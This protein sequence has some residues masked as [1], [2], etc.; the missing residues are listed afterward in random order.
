MLLPFYLASSS[1]KN[2]AVCESYRSL[3][4]IGRQSGIDHDRYENYACWFLLFW[5]IWRNFRS[6]RYQKDI[7]FSRRTGQHSVI[8]QFSKCKCCA[9]WSSIRVKHQSSWTISGMIC[10]LKGLDDQI[11]IGFGWYIP[12]DN[13]SGKKIHNDTKVIP[14]TSGFEICKVT[15]PDQVGS[16]LMKVLMQVI[17]ITA[18][19]LFW[20]RNGFWFY[21]GHRWKLP[22]AHQA[23]H[24]TDTDVNAIVTT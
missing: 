19:W 1:L 22:G 8:K 15:C 4:Y 6:R 3:R 18:G 13:F 23:V 17:S 14:L 20:V 12:G 7:P 9:L 11:C 2:Y 21:C 16:L 24:S 5:D 10:F